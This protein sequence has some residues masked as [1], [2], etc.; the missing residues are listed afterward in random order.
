MTLDELRKSVLVEKLSADEQ[1]DLPTE[2]EC[3]NL[4]V[5]LLSSFLPAHASTQLL[6]ALFLMNLISPGSVI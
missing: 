6:L 5:G 4:G 2:N 3:N 1:P